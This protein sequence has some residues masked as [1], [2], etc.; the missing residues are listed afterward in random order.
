MTVDSRKGVVDSTFCE[1]TL[2]DNEI[3]NADLDVFLWDLGDSGDV[4]A[5]D[6]SGSAVLL[7]SCFFF[8]FFSDVVCED[9][10]R[11]DLAFFSDLVW[12]SRLAR[13]LA[14]GLFVRED[15]AP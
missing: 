4:P 1:L 12:S 9:G 11:E 2:N 8:F 13:Q 14:W 7:S 3:S 5:E 6:S 10:V 15:L